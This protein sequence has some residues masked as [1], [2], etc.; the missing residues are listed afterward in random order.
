M[1]CHAEVHLKSLENWEKTLDDIMSRYYHECGEDDG[2]FWDYWSIGGNW[3]RIHEAPSY[4]SYFMDRDFE[5]KAMESIGQGQEC[6][7]RWT[8]KGILGGSRSAFNI[9]K[10]KDLPKDFEA[11]TLVANDQVFHRDDDLDKGINI[12]KKLKELGITDGYVV[13]VDYHI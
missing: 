12:K 2:G 6:I 1:H 8:M 13:T 5:Y 4:H 3:D 11:M 7:K 10:V 9:A